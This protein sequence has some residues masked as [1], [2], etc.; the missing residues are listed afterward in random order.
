MG[1]SSS[2]WEKADRVI[3]SLVSGL[4]LEGIV[5]SRLDH[6]QDVEND[7]P[8]VQIQVYVHRAIQVEASSTEI[9]LM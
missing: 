9:S 6:S 8:K 7:S 1:N 2:T 4:D 3:D 5:F